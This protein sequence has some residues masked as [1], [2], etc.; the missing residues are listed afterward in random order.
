M[1]KNFFKDPLFHFMLVAFFI[2]IL[3]LVWQPNQKI[4]K[5]SLI[6]DKEL[7]TVQM[8]WTK[9]WNRPPTTA[10]LKS[11][12]AQKK[13]NEMLFNE[14]ITMGL[15]KQDKM[16]YERLIHKIKHL[17]SNVN[18]N[19]NPSKKQLKLYY[20]NHIDDYRQDG[21]FSF[22]Q[23]FISI[24]HDNPI[25]KADE[26][27]TLLEDTGVNP[28]DIDHY[29]DAYNAHHIK[30]ATQSE[31]IKMYG[32]SFYKQLRVLKKFKW[33]KPLISNSGVHIIMITQHTHGT[34]KPFTEVQDIVK[35]DFIDATKNEHYKSRL[36]SILNSQ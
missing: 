10:E 18:V 21:Q 26:M 5:E 3:H 31:I 19:L 32:E 6:S 14:A 23:L 9:E 25:Q 27:L 15:H 29:G 8:K 20:K 2:Y 17:F 11:L 34:I 1:L 13:Q 16:I 35:G 28:E 36:K 7:K 4:Q 24:N 12:I 30:N 22:S 33:S